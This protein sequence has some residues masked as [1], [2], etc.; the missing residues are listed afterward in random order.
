MSKSRRSF[1]PEFKQEA[2]DLYRRSGKSGCQVARE[3]GIGNNWGQVLHCNIRYGNNWGQVL[4]C[5]IRYATVPRMARPLRLEFPGAL[6]H[7]T[8][9]GNAQQPI[10]RDDEDRRRFLASLAHAVDRYSWVMHAYCLMDNHYHLLLETP[11]PTLARGMRHLNGTCTQAYNR[12]HQR[13]G[14]LFQGR[15]KAILVQ[16]Q[17][18][19]L[20]L[21]RYVVLNPVRAKMCQRAEQWPWGSF[22]ATAGIEP[23][24]TWLTTGWV[25]AQF[26]ATR[27]QAQKAYRVFVGEGLAQRPWEA[28]RGQ[29]YLGTEE[30]VEMLTTNQEPVPEVPRAQ[31]QG[32]R[33]SLAEVLALRQ[34][35]AKAI[36][37]AYQDYGYRLREIAEHYGVHYATVSRWLR[38]G[39][40]QSN[41]RRTKP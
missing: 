22:R 23:A 41:A 39:E 14:H 32:R 25:L 19:L 28:L 33:P 9:R 18:Y 40:E 6:Y 24:P 11:R 5:N 1:T 20:E 21:C 13:V 35:S 38:A 2:V 16:R 15:Y 36:T 3:L 10:Y 34:P 29:I 4:H 31:W 30:F 37:K 26:A 17:P 27:S 8:A 7:V 12:R